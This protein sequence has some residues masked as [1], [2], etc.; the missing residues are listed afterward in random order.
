MV[1]Q[2][3]KLIMFELWIWCGEQ[4]QKVFNLHRKKTSFF[5]VIDSLYE[6]IMNLPV[7]IHAIYTADITC[8]YERIPLEGLDNLHDALG[9]VIR[10]GS[11]NTMVPLGNILSGFTSIQ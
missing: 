1:T 8:C 7:D 3:L 4:S 11:H 2:A 6:F 5:W 10:K 9:F